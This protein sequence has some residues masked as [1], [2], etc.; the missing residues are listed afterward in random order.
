ML[1]LDEPTNDLDI[2]TLTVLEDF[3]DGWPG[4]LVVVSHDRYFLERVCDSV[5][6]LYGDGTI[7]MLPRG[8][9]EYLEHRRAQ[10]GADAAES[11]AV[12]AA[13]SGTRTGD[14]VPTQAERRDARKTLTRLERQIER[15]TSEEQRLHTELAE[16]AADPARLVEL[17]G[18]L[19][20]VVAQKG[21]LEEQWLE[22]AE[23]AQ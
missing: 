13:A 14:G 5:L 21:E 8:V 23:A 4:T 20:A 6:G 2:E 1:L 16:H 11:R 19:R 15:L 12:A 17:D 10:H 22:V 9:D 7:R 18:R 3:L